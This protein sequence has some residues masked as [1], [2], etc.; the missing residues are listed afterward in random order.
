VDEVWAFQ[1]DLSGYGPIESYEIEFAN[2]PHSSIRGLQVD[3][4]MS[5][6]P[7][8]SVAALMMLGAGMMVW[9][10]WRRRIARVLA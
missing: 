10:V 1:W 4:V 9:A 6:V 8:P 2:Y 3:L 5:A 7:E